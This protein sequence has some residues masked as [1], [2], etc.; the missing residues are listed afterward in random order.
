MSSDFDMSDASDFEPVA[1]IKAAP[2]KA[3][4]KRVAAVTKKAKVVESEEEESAS[5]VDFDDDEPSPP[6]R[7]TATKKTALK[8]STADNE[9]DVDEAPSPAAT[10]GKKK[11]ATDTYQKLSQLEHVLK[12]PDTYIGSVEASQEKL[13]VYDSEQN[14]MVNKNVSI[15]PGLY[16]IFDEILVNAADNKQRDPNM[17]TLKVTFDRENNSVSVYNNG[18]G[19]PIEMH[20]KEKIWI[21]ELIFGNLLTSSNYDDDQKK[22]TGG[23]NGYGAKLCNIFSTEFIVE[24]ADKGNKKK[25][26]QVFSSN[27]SKKGVPKITENSKGEE[28]TRITFKP[29]LKKFSLEEMDADLESL[30]KRRVY[31]M[32]GTM[33]GCKVFLNNERIKVKNFKQYVEMYVNSV[34]P[35]ATTGKPPPIVHEVVSDRWEIA[36]TVSDGS[37]NQVS[38]VNGIATTKGGTHVNYIADQIVTKISDAV[39]KKNKAGASV[40]PHMIKNHLWV[41]IN[42]LI[43]NP[44]F[45]SQTKENMTLRQ[46]AFG[47]KCALS[48]DFIKKVLKSGVLENVLNFAKFKADQAMKKTDGH[49]RSRITGLPKLEDANNA[50]TKNGS[51]CTLILTE[52]DSA[53]ALAVSGLS[54]V[55]RDNFGVF[56]L[57][58]KLLNVREAS[59]AQIMA[60]SEI[61]A[62]KQIMGLQHNKTYTSAADLR[63]GHLMIMTDQDHD[64]SHIKGLIINF[65]ETF[66]P[67]LLQIPGFLI[68][69]I[70]PIVKCTKG[71]KEITFFTIP[72]YE[73][74]KEANEEGKGW[75]IKY[76]KGLGTSTAADAKKYFSDLD[77]H[78]K[79]FHTTQ[80][81]DKE[82]IDM[83]FSKK[84]AD[85]RKEWLRQFKPGTYMDHSVDKIPLADF[86]NKELILFSMADNVRSIPS[87]VDGLKP[88]QR[89]VI[90]GTFKRK[91]KGEIKVAQLAGYVA[92]H[93]AYHHG[94][95]SLTQTIVGLAQQFVGSNNIN[96]LLPNGQFG[97][98]MQGGKDAASARYIFTE[99]SPLTRKLFH[100]DDDPLLTYLNDD[101]QNI[102][103]QFYAP[104][105][106]MVLVNGSEGIGTGWSS[107][108]P[109]F[110][111]EDLVANLR[112]L[113][114]G[115][116]PEE[117][118]PW[119]RGFTGSIEKKIGKYELKG[120]IT[121]LDDNTVEI[122]ELPIRYWTQ[123][124]K[125]FLEV[126][127][128]GT[129]KVPAFIKDYSEYH[130]DGTVH[131]IVKLTDKGMAEAL[132]EGLEEKF[133]L[134]TSVSTSNMVAFDTEGRIRKYNN[135]DEIL[136]EFYHLRLELYQ[137]RK[138]YL[139]NELMRQFERLS[140]QARFVQM[141]CDHELIVSNKKRKDLVAELKEKGFKSF[142]KNKEAKEAGEMEEAL[143]DETADA[144]DKGYDYLL[145]MAIW[146]LTREKVAK[147]N[148]DKDAKEREL[149]ELLKLSAKDIWE[150]DLQAFMEEWHATLET[151]EKLIADAKSGKKPTT[152]RKAGTKLEAR[153]TL[154]AKVK[155]GSDDDSDFE[156]KKPAAK[157]AK[158]STTPAK[159]KPAAKQT[160][161][162]FTKTEPSSPDEEVPVPARKTAA[163]T[164]KAAAA[165]PATKKALKVESDESDEEFTALKVDKAPEP[166]KK[167]PVVQPKA[168]I[169]D[170][171]DDDYMSKLAKG[172]G[173]AKPM[174]S[175]SALSKPTTKPAAAKKPSPIVDLSEDEE[176]SATLSNVIDDESSPEKPKAK[177]APVKKA[178]LSAA[179]SKKSLKILSDE[180]ESEE[181][182]MKPAAKAKAAPAAK[183]AAPA[184]SA[185]AAK[186]KAVPVM[187]DSDSASESEGSFQEESEGESDFDEDD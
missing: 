11:T 105:L 2:K 76:Y 134:T 97:T 90:F 109:N 4:V 54:V 126:G 25:Y 68:E 104:I 139:A 184:R 175:F 80:D 181:E 170:D 63:Y 1:P 144:G 114:K 163:S 122:T 13:W 128:A 142:P 59:H 174:F 60:N 150:H 121:Q 146:S 135:V 94:E 92:E 14:Q 58:G 88:G 34:A 115:K 37:F 98:R 113:M 179:A 152:G 120:T 79:Y 99:L 108:I 182:V 41:F 33:K 81:G 111:P 78:L 51:R 169:M 89:K 48:E 154:K 133:K 138:D 183:N 47:S 42:C 21:P 167:M 10:N 165:K 160:K 166:A 83:A 119:Y 64:G 15:V 151:D 145:G 16:K 136:R 75:N 156:A 23:R 36:F 20:D 45:D 102:E 130:T 26:K 6:P 57:R 124:M 118:H 123:N 38:F 29:D 141:I 3:P 70:T 127:I 147:L 50:G 125:E 22:V 110:N 157:K 107:F 137:K 131:F 164:A 67:S 74:W 65:L 28:Y 158:A 62:I 117:M 85:D 93:S 40:K 140:N 7:K 32:A 155:R 100:N 69:F 82:L 43:E 9:M 27:M 172:T 101:G 52:G 159:A 44:A 71:K 84:K 153:P 106:P 91:L 178:A 176:E 5:E 56:P 77:Q 55:G 86:I 95:Q 173:D 18:R 72:E 171:S 35:D 162:A 87:M 17:D 116:E 112:R 66:Y 132:K 185:R 31:D 24:T 103:P 46:S 96:L 53:K 148:A 73:Y 180:D 168:T 143:E 129:E 8:E 30:I 186:A 19:I 49:K 177:A 39:K 61:Q 187:I 161:L 149:D 12:R